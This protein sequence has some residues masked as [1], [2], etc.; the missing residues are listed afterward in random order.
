MH[1]GLIGWQ[2]IT[3]ETP[4]TVRVEA[5]FESAHRLGVRHLEL[6]VPGWDEPGEVDRVKEL[7]ERYQI[8]VHLGFGDDYIGNADQQPTEPF[9]EL[10]ERVCKPLGVQ[11]I[12]TASRLHGGRWLCQPPLEEQLDRLA[13]A[14]A[15][16][17][18]IAEANGVVLAIENHADYRGYELA[19]VLERVGSPG[20]GARLD[21]GNAYTVIEEPLAATEALARYTVATHIKDQ[22]VESEPGNRGV[23][24]GGLL[25]LRNCVLG[26]GHVDFQAILSL[27]AERSPLGDDLVLTLEVPRETMEDSLAYARR[28]F[29][30]YLSE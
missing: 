3:R 26:E 21:T 24:P 22:I 7:Q 23:A 27:L 30:P 15:R 8:D 19:G 25:A 1:L 14:L 4:E 12:G 28:A 9:A 11:V 10:V 29:A 6:W 16:L 20:L 17:A 2:L 13:S 18:P 5:Q